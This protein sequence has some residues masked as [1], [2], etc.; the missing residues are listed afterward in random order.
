MTYEP[1]FTYSWHIKSQPISSIL[2]RI[3]ILQRH[4]FLDQNKLNCCI[5]YNN[6]SSKVLCTMCSCLWTVKYLLVIKFKVH[7]KQSY[8]I[9]KS[10]PTPNHWVFFYAVCPHE[11]AVFYF[12][13]NRIWEKLPVRVDMTWVWTA[14]NL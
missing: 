5:Y 12:I 14:W 8:S 1:Y 9:I 11:S 6:Y 10:K 4:W 7:N 3:L 2:M 13:F